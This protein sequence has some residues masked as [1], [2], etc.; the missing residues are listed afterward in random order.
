MSPRG[1]RQKRSTRRHPRSTLTL[2]GALEMAEAVIRKEAD[3]WA[4]APSQ[5]AQERSRELHA[6][7]NEL[8][9]RR[10]QLP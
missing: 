4:L 1:H 10:A 9:L 2:R 7:A 5:A 8:R 6:R 3:I